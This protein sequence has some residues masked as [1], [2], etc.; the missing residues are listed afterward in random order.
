MFQ[1][2][3]ALKLLIP[4]VDLNQINFLELFSLIRPEKIMMAAK[5]ASTELF[6][7]SLVLA[8][9]NL[10]TISEYVVVV[11]QRNPSLRNLPFTK[12]MVS[13]NENAFSTSSLFSHT[14]FATK[15]AEQTTKPKK[16]Q[17]INLF[18]TCFC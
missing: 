4:R 9:S 8:R 13:A 1:K 15:E 14:T 5:R 3:E 7:R 2:S 17:L 18:L 10:T 11:I 12:M 16:V 6:G